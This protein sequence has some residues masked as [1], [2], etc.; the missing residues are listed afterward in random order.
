MPSPRYRTQQRVI[1]KFSGFFLLVMIYYTYDIYLG[2]VA[3]DMFHWQATIYGPN[4]S[5]YAGG[6][7]LVN[8]H[9]PPDYPFKPP[10]VICHLII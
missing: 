5:P 2:P 4:E 6:V 9:F 10:K 8:I 1:H 7:F 3:E